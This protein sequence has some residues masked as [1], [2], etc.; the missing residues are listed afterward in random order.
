MTMTKSTQSPA[1]TGSELLNTYY[2]RRVSLFIGFISS[3]VF[4]PSQLKTC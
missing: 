4:F 1:F 2:Q 3:L